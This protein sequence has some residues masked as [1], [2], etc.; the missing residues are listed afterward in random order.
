MTYN[1][2]GSVDEIASTKAVQTYFQENLVWLG[3]DDQPVETVIVQSDD[4]ITKVM[5]LVDAVTGAD[6]VITGT[7]NIVLDG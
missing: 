1:E 3:A 7:N 6:R 5:T 2:T 4:G